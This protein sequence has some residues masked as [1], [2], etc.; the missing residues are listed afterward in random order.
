MI[1]SVSFVDLIPNI[2]DFICFITYTTYFYSFRRGVRFI[3]TVFIRRRVINIFNINVCSLNDHTLLI[4]TIGN[5]KSP[6][7]PDPANPLG[8]ERVE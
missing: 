1:Y 6:L 7:N 4:C 5:H 2:F 3:G 8:K